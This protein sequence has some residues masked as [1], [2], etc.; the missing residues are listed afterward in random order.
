M[1]HDDGRP[2]YCELVDVDGRSAFG[3]AVLSWLHNGQALYRPATLNGNPIKDLA[4][5]KVYFNRS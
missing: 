4:A 3:D 2:G 1:I 5:L